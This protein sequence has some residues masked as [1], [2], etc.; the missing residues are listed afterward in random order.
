MNRPNAIPLFYVDDIVALKSDPAARPGTVLRVHLNPDDF[1][2]DPHFD[3]SRNL[4]PDEVEV[5][6]NALPPLPPKVY[7]QHELNLVDR[8]FV[9]GDAVVDVNDRS[10]AG[11]VISVAQSVDLRDL[12]NNKNSLQGVD[13]RELK[14][15]YPFLTT[16][17]PVFKDEFVG[18]IHH[19]DRLLCRVKFSNGAEGDI[20]MHVLERVAKIQYEDGRKHSDNPEDDEEPPLLEPGMVILIPRDT[21]SFVVKWTPTSASTTVGNGF[22]LITDLLCT[23]L[24]VQWVESSLP[25]H[26]LVSW[27]SPVTKYA[28][29]TL[30]ECT[31]PFSLGSCVQFTNAR[32]PGLYRVSSVTTKVTVQWQDASVTTDMPVTSVRIPLVMDDSLVWP[33]DIVWNRMGELVQVDDIDDLKVGVAQSVDAVQ[34]IAIVRWF[35]ADWSVLGEPTTVSLLEISAHPN[36]VLDLMSK[37]LVPGNRTNKD[38]TWFGELTAIHLDGTRTFRLGNGKEAV[39]RFDQVAPMTLPAMGPDGED[40]PVMWGDDGWMD[41]EVMDGDG[42]SIDGDSDREYDDEDD[43]DS[44]HSDAEDGDEPMPS[45]DPPD[46][47]MSANDQ[48]TEPMSESDATAVAPEEQG[49][50]VE[51]EQVSVH[52]DVNDADVGDKFEVLEESDDIPFHYSSPT[53]MSAALMRAIRKEHALFANLPD[54]ILVRSFADRMDLLVVLVFGPLDTPYARCPFLFEIQFPADYPNSP[55]KVYHVNKSG[56]RLNPNLHE[57]GKLCLSLLGTWSGVGSESWNPATSTILQLLVSV[58]GLILIKE[59]YYLEP[60][61]MKFTKTEDG[62]A[63]SRAYSERTV[64]LSVKNMISLVDRPPVYFKDALYAY[65]SVHGKDL[66]AWARSHLDAQPDQFTEGAKIMLRPVVERLE[67]V[68]AKVE[69]EAR[70]APSHEESFAS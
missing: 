57:D 29:L 50:E 21:P 12:R 40:G 46:A 52:V 53:P 16:G 24:E 41:E 64:I 59:P 20:P 43:H 19:A 54:G 23:E 34:R 32:N 38:Y 13:Y 66:I 42:L 33:G 56:G 48:S 6:F 8:S 1:E 70:E 30:L 2:A 14:S 3:P 26:A 9:P 67:K 36:F 61:F 27:P 62:E 60:G 31:T 17:T 51:P 68:V 10:R 35:N 49:K 65:Y 18:W 55:P 44:V 58:Q 63:N 45:L 28:D 39:L 15:A 11:T 4:A 69:K 7:K 37:V 5:S 47:D 25:D 22:G